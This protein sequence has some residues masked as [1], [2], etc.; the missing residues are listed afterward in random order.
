[1]TG[2]VAAHDGPDLFSGFF[3]VVRKPVGQITTWRA[4]YGAPLWSVKPFRHRPALFAP[5]RT[6]AYRTTQVR[7]GPVSRWTWSLPG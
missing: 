7:G 6:A 1:M 2:R 3:S 5:Y 4:F